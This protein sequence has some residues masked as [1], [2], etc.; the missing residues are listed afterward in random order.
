M[1]NQL[2]EQLKIIFLSN[3]HLFHST[4]QQPH[5]LFALCSFTELELKLFNHESIGQSSENKS[6]TIFI[7]NSQF[8]S[9]INQRCQM[10]GGY[11]FMMGGFAVFL[12]EHFLDLNSWLD[13][14]KHLKILLHCLTNYNGHCII[15]KDSRRKIIC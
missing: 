4:L 9:F 12:L 1:I 10:F 13:K 11:S 14:R 8:R 3:S 5:F 7:I 15:E 6:P 2:L